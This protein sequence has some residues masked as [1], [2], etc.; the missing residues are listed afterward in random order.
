MDTL[1]SWAHLNYKNVIYLKSGFF[2]SGFSGK[3]SILAFDIEE[4]KECKYTNEIDKWIYQNQGSKRFE[5]LTFCLMPYESADVFTSS[6]LYQNHYYNSN[7]VKVQ[8]Q[9]LL[10]TF[11]Q[12]IVYD[13]ELHKIIYQKQPIAKISNLNKNNCTLNVNIED[14]SSNMT[15]YYYLS[16]IEKIINKI[17][18][19]DL[20]QVNFTRKYFSSGFVD[21]LDILFLK[22]ILKSKS[23]YSAFFKDEDF[24]LIS[25]SPERLFCK[26]NNTVTSNPIKGSV[27]ISE[28]S[29]KK[30]IEEELL[31]VKNRAENLMITD[32]IRNELSMISKAGDVKAELFK[33]DFY[34]HIAHLSSQVSC[35]VNDEMKPSQILKAIFP[36]GSM[37]GAPKIAAIKVALELEASPRGFYSGSIGYFD[38]FKNGYSNVLNA[39]FSVTIRSIIFRQLADKN[40]YKI[41]TQAGGGITHLSNPLLELEELK[42]K[43]SMIFDVLKED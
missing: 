39:D 28:S 36:P 23:F 20:L 32:L 15:D 31:N 22:L 43:L 33:M 25:S 6:A 40:Y 29:T 35:L 1:F 14:F 4:K 41:E 17:K 42:A 13:N 11:K 7:T 10:Y 9:I 24:T 30:K 34:P 16:S 5:N 37:T 2:K 18:N 19:G 38:S 26:N 21:N 27:K 8:N 3:Y 12:V